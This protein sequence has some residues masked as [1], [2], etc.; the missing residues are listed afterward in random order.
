M[1]K[2]FIVLLAFLSFSLVG[3]D[4]VN[5]VEVPVVVVET[6][7]VEVEVIVKEIQIVEV[8]V[9]VKETEVIYVPEFRDTITISVFFTT[10]GPAVITIAQGSVAYIMEIAYVDKLFA[11]PMFV[12]IQ[13]EKQIDGWTEDYFFFDEYSGDEPFTFEV[14]DE[15]DWM[16]QVQAIL[17]SNLPDLWGDFEELYNVMYEDCYSP[18]VE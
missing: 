16:A 5:T 17:E 6:E 15:S 8:P 2:I 3:C 4:L 14:I 12:P 7:I 13:I 9:I 18:E 10:D 11:A 1:K